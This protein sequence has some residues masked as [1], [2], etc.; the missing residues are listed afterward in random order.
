[1]QVAF[2]LVKTLGYLYIWVLILRIILQWIRAD[3]RN[4][5][6]QFVVR[7]TNPL[8]V[9]LRRIVPPLRGLDMATF[10]A[11]FLVQFLLC[12]VLIYMA[13]QSIPGFWQLAFV[14]AL[15][16]VHATLRLYMFILIVWVIM[17]W[18][19]AG[20]YNPVSTLFARL[21]EPLL[22]P[23]RRFIPPIGG[24]DLSALFVIIGLQ[25]LM[26]LIPIPAGY[27]VLFWGGGFI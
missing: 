17:S 1:M 15:R 9:P 4:P 19:A 7:T 14:T 16:L 12:V 26:L 2:F 24:L 18:V 5:I 8:V 27:S 25:A 21:S 23:V 13:T 10:V 20:Q 6:S 3:Y 11:V 22:A